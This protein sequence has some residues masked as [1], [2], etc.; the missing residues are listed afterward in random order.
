MPETRKC[1]ITYRWDDLFGFGEEEV[2]DSIESFIEK[3]PLYTSLLT[4]M[5]KG[6]LRI[7]V[8]VPNYPADVFITKYAEEE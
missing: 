2:Y 8:E 1:K 5:Y 6:E 4:V 7:R 3:Y